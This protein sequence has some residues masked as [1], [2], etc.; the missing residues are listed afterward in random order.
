MYSHNHLGKMILTAS[1]FFLISCS[2]GGG[3]AG[4]SLNADDRWD[5]MARE[6]DKPLPAD[7]PDN[8]QTDLSPP[9]TAIRS[10]GEVNNFRAILGKADKEY[11]GI[12]TA[13]DRDISQKAEKAADKRSLWRTVQLHLSRLVIIQKNMIRAIK[14]LDNMSA[15]GDQAMLEHGRVLLKEIDRRIERTQKYLDDFTPDK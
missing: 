4:P 8:E 12:A 2:G 14:G 15:P 7:E 6:R 11:F 1:L 5:W 3:A 9:P 10:D 13:L